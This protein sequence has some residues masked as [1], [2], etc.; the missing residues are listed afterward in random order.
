MNK[1][2]YFTLTGAINFIAFIFLALFV[3]YKN[4]KSKINIRF[5]IFNL[6]IAIWSFGYIFWPISKTSDSTLFWFQFLHCGANFISITFF[7]FVITLLDKNKKRVLFFGYLL[8][9]LILPLIFTPYFIKGMKPI[10]IFPYWGVPGPLYY[11]FLANFFGF[12]LLSMIFL[13]KSYLHSVSSKRK[14]QLK[15][16]LTGA[17]AG[18][19]GGST[20]Y[21]QFFN[22]SFPPYLNILV[23]VYAAIIVYAIVAHELLDINIIFRKTLLYSVLATIL[24]IIYFSIILVLENIFRI[25]YG[26]QSFPISFALIILFIVLFQPLKNKTQSIIDK[27]FF[28]GSIDQIDEENIKLREELRKSEKLK[29]VATLA[30]GMAHEIKNPLTSIKTFTEYLPEKCD[31]PG[32]IKK[33]NNVVGAEVE[34]INSIVK[35]LLDFSKPKELCLEESDLN[36]LLNETLELLN[37]DLLKHNIKVE[38][39][40]S[41]IPPVKVDP[42]QIK[43]IFLNILLNALESI[44]NSGTITVKTEIAGDNKISILIEDTGKGIDREDLKHIFDPFFTKKDGGS[45]LGLS[46]V[47]GIIN[48]HGGKINVKSEPGKGTSFEIILS[49][50]Y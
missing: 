47:H 25:Y 37:N 14:N 7:H 33:F 12:S 34:K 31:D 41:R 29:A 17:I 35:Q 39:S 26:Y 21:F 1:M 42:S 46:V 28:R 36:S 5:A 48:K 4:K 18:Y 16:I 3:Y 27:Y 22:I 43:Q 32:F 8:S 19:L 45:G 20:N 30:A 24:T 10:G 44:E 15:Y 13:F 11:V 49:C 2:L 40:Y 9:F 6:S 23:F 38:K 50:S